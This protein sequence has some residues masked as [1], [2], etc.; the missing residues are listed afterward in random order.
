MIKATRVVVLLGMM[1][2][3]AAIGAS[4]ALALLF[5][6]K[7]SEELFL[8]LS[9]FGTGIIIETASKN[10]VGC[11][12]VLGDGLILNQTDVAEKILF[13]FH[14]C[15]ASG[16]SCNSADEPAGL[17]T[18][19]DLDALLVTLLSGRYGFLLLAEKGNMA[20]FECDGDLETETLKGTIIGEFPNDSIGKESETEEKKLI[21]TPGLKAGEQSIKDWWT[22]QGVKGPPKLE[23]TLSG[24]INESNVESDLQMQPDM[25]VPGG[26]EL[27][28]GVKE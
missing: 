7:N 11:Q 13:T 8:L 6:V 2:A 27:C 15:D 20:E 21:Y 4:P 22:L 24:L 25:R 3:F 26:I 23:D 16:G 9:L 14:G 1:L 5:L 18:T 12:A 28:H 17:I 19:L 10:L